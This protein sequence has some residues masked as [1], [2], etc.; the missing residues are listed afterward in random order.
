MAETGR[1]T[2]CRREAAAGRAMQPVTALRI[3]I[4]VTVLVIWEGRLGIRLALPR[5]RALAGRRSARALVRDADRPELFYL[6]SRTRRST[7][8]ASRMVIGGV[9]GLAVG[10][11]ARRQQSSMS[12][13]L[14]SLSVLSRTAARRSSFSR[15]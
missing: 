6:P 10:I 3:A 2:I 12:A 5:R 14:R 11:A 15:S 9:S 1:L 7:R 8:S 13:R 4:I